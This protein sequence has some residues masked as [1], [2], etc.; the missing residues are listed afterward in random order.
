MHP[1]A[2]QMKNK[3]LGGS[4]KVFHSVT[5]QPSFPVKKVL[6]DITTPVFFLDVQTSHSRVSFLAA[7][8]LQTFV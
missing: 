7:G 2:Y 3:S 1:T 8:F 4:L 6:P 5:T